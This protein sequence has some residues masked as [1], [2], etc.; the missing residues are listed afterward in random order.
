MNRLFIGVIVVGLSLAAC[1][2]PTAPAPRTTAAPTATSE[3]QKYVEMRQRLI[4]PLGGLIV[5]TQNRSSTARNHMMAFEKEAE[6][7]L[8]VI[9][10]DMSVNANR[11]DSAIKSTRNAYLIG[12]VEELD[13]VRLRLLEIR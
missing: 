6:A 13:R 7:I 12:D 5:A 11:L 10:N 3:S 8:P 4:L 9:E 2:S 1:A